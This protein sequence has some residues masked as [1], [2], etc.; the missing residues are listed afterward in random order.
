MLNMIKAKYLIIYIVL[1]FSLFVYGCGKTNISNDFKFE[2]LPDMPNLRASHSAITMKNGKV[3]IIGNMCWHIEERSPVQAD[4]YDPI[5]K[6]FTSTKESDLFYICHDS[7]LIKLSDGKILIVYGSGIN[8]KTKHIL[9]FNPQNNTFKEIKGVLPI[10]I[11]GVV[12]NNENVLFS[13][14]K[15]IEVYNTNNWKVEKTAKLNK[16]RKGFQMIVVPDGNVLFIGG[17]ESK[18]LYANEVESYNLKTNEV[19]IVGK[20]KIPRESH[21]CL[22]LNNG[23]IIILGGFTFIDD[24]SFFEEIEI[25]NPKTNQSTIVAKTSNY[26]GENPD[27][28]AIVLRDGRVLIHS[29]AKNILNENKTLKKYLKSINKKNDFYPNIQIF[30]PKTNLISLVISDS[31]EKKSKYQITLLQDGNILVTGGMETLE[32]FMGNDYFLLNTVELITIDN[33]K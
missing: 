8:K 25:Y 24:F 11:Y 18:Y 2:K 27:F 26:I 7:N 15:I 5:S 3:L 13:D 30:D 10:S 16:P 9:T 21:Q 32:T 22:L 17:E 29:A 4:I 31:T 33:N 14:G 12:L 1:F 6:T 23:N 28:K 20:I 19:K